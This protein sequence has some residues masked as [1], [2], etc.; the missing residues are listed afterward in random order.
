MRQPEEDQREKEN[1]NG[2][3]RKHSEIVI[4]PTQI[5]TNGT[6]SPPSITT[7][8]YSEALAVAGQGWFHTILLFVTGL[9]LMSVVNETVNVGFI[10]SAAECDLNLT[11]SDKGVLNGAGFLGV[12]SSS[13]VWG[14]L[15]DTWGRR[16]VLLLASTG[17]LIISILSTFAPHVWVLIGARYLVGIFVSGNAATSYAYLAEFHGESSRAKVISW[18]AMFMA[19]GLI[20][21]PSLAWLIIPL[22]DRF[23]LYLFGMRYDMWR[24]YLLLC[25]LDLIL[26]IAGLLYLPESGKFLLT[27]GH[28]EK[29]VQIL[30]KIYHLNQGEPEHT[31]PVKSITLDAIDAPYADEMQRRSNLGLRYLWQQTVPL[32]RAPLLWHTLKASVL[33]F[34]L[35]ATSSGL[36]LWIPDILNTYVQHEDMQLCDVIALMH[37]NKTAARTNDPTAGSTCPIAINANI[38][39]ITSAMGVV[40]LACYILNGF[41]INRVGKTT[42]LN[43][44]FVVCGICGLAVLWTSDFYLTLILIAAFVSSGCLGGVLSAISVDLFPTNYRAMAMCLI[45]MTGRFGAMAGSNIIAYLLTYNCNL[46]FILFGGSLLVCALI[47]ATLTET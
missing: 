34:G 42:L 35:F 21:L 12:V 37:A 9:C 27:N 26:I 3:T 11:F 38:F 8:T 44:W 14:F 40:F 22:D 25:S 47:G 43:G 36:F 33:M 46:I 23:E 4:D 29:V 6:S 17:A 32:F 1:A 13:Y 39:L 31:F 15:S 41:I 10:I 24:I 18:A 28:R 30:A 7:H 5:V 20:F 19:I 16:R 45:L 2:E